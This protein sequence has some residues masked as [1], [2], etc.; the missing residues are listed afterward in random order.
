MAATVVRLSILSNDLRQLSVTY[1]SFSST[2]LF[3]VPEEN[4]SYLFIE[5]Q[6]LSS[7]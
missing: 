5:N 4:N 6:K 7:T 3:Q 1:D 2:L